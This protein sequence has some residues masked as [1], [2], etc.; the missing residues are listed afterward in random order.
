MPVEPKD[1]RAWLKACD[2][3][4]SEAIRAERCNARGVVQCVTCPA[5]GYW[6][7]GKIH[8]GHFLGKPESIRYCELNIAPQCATCNLTGHSFTA[9]YSR[10]KAESVATAYYEW[11]LETYGQKVIDAI[12]RLK[13]DS[14]THSIEELRVMR[15]WF[16]WRRDRAVEEK[17]L[18]HLSNP[19]GRRG[20]ML[21]GRNDATGG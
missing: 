14:R 19:R 3:A 8:A 1:R 7:G 20:E 6:K 18:E 4:L 16:T 12:K 21:A 10:Q 2:R 13:A 15:F 9:A 11:M 5:T 17:G